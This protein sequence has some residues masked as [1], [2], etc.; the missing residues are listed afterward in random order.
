[1][2]HHGRFLRPCR[3]LIAI[4]A[5]RFVTTAPE[6]G[7]AL[8]G[9]HFGAGEDG[10]VADEVVLTMQPEVAGRI[11]IVRARVDGADRG[12]YPTA[13]AAAHTTT[14][15]WGGAV[16]QSGGQRAEA[17]D[18]QD[19]FHGDVGS[20]HRWSITDFFRYNLDASSEARHKITLMHFFKDGKAGWLS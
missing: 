15:G 19:A 10:Q 9:C 2:F 7:I 4:Q 12:G 16:G 11:V 14:A 17:Q 3:A 5:A 20:R 8:L 18:W 6:R 13:A 1:M